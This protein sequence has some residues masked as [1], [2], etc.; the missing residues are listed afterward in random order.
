M[1][2][3][4]PPPKGSPVGKPANHVRTLGILLA[5]STPMSGFLLWIVVAVILGEERLEGESGQTGLGLAVLVAPL[6]IGVALALW[7]HFASEPPE[8]TARSLGAMFIGLGV[9]FVLLGLFSLLTETDA[10]I[11][12]GILVLAG[13]TTAAGGWVILSKRPE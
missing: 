9:V 2:S 11:G 13:L 4:P 10:S 6:L 1:A 8:L 3:T 12:G 7:A 5:L